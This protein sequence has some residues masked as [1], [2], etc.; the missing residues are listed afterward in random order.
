MQ[1]QASRYILPILKKLGGTCPP[2][3]THLPPMCTENVL[4]CMD[5]NGCED[6]IPQIP[7][8]T[9]DVSCRAE[10]RGGGY[11]RRESLQERWV[12]SRVVTSL[13][14][15]L[16]LASAALPLTRQ[17]LCFLP[18]YVQLFALPHYRITPLPHYDQ[19]YSYCCA[20]S[21]TT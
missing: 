5:K 6:S 15:A 4:V 7:Q 2:C 11:G 8:G 21:T 14:S 12:E 16:I 18:N 20:S 9:F 3:P 10:K 17:Q 1:V 19:R 13:T